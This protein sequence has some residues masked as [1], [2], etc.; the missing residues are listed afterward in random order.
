MDRKRRAALFEAGTVL[1]LTA[2]SAVGS[3]MLYKQTLPRPKGTSQDIV[4]EFADPKK[5]EEYAE[6]MKPVADWLAEQKLEDIYITSNDGLR[7]HALYLAAQK[8]VGRTVLFHHGFTSHAI[9]NGNHAKFFHDLGYEVIL[10]DLR[11]HG[12]SEGDYVGFGILDR[13]DTLEWVRYVKDRFGENQTIV[14]H[15]TSMGAATVLMAL[16]MEEIQKSVSAVIADCAFTSP[17]AIFSHVMKKDYHVPFTAPIIAMNGLYSKAKAGYA[18]SDYSTLEALREN[19]VP[20]L[21]IHGAEDKF[22]PVWMSRENYDACHAKKELLIV[23]GAG[24][25][26]SLFENQKLYE[27][28]EEKF[29]NEVFEEDSSIDENGTEKEKCE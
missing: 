22:V 20:V 7:L 8:P 26:S 15:G 2:A 6:K 5:F 13:F 29:L 4:D 17:A 10:L 21:L 27:S 28:T 23:E 14:L 25:G 12:E 16:G 24:H 9:D 19:E 11:A 1:G 18:F 3:W